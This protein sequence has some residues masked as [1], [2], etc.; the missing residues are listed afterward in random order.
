MFLALLMVFG[1]FPATVFTALAAGVPDSLVTSLAQLYDG[2]E[3]RAREELEALYDAGL[4]DSDGNMVPLDIREDGKSVNLEDIA[5][6]IA[7]GE[8]VGELTVNGNAVT[9]EK[10]TQLQQV[11]AMLEVLRLIDKDVEITDEHVANLQSLLEGIADGSIDLSDVIFRGEM[12]MSATR[13]ASLLG[14]T[15]NLP[16]NTGSGTVDATEGKYSQ[17]Y[18]SGSTYEDSHSFTLSDPNNTTW[19]TTNSVTSGAVVTI[20]CDEKA[21]ADSTFTVTATLN[22]AQSVPVSF[23]WAAV[24]DVI[25]LTED[26]ESGA[27]TSGTVTWAAN[28]TQL[29]KTFQVTLGA[30]SGYWVGSQ[31]FVINVGNIN[32]AVFEGG[33]TALS[34]TVP[35]DANDKTN[36]INEY[37]NDTQTYYDFSHNSQVALPDYTYEVYYKKVKLPSSG[38]VVGTAPGGILRRLF[39][40]NPDI[41]LSGVQ[42][43]AKDNKT[44]ANLFA[45]NSQYRFKELTVNGGKWTEAGG[46]LDVVKNGEAYYIAAV[47]GTSVGSVTI[48]TTTIP[49]MNEVESVSVPAG[50]YYSGQVVPVT[51]KLK[52]PAIF[53]G[54]TT[55]TV[56]NVDSPLLNAADTEAKAFTFGYT[57]RDIDTGAINVTEL[58]GTIKNADNLE[59]TFEKDFPTTDFGIDDGVTL[60]SD[61]KSGSLDWDSVTYGVDDADSGDQTVTVVIPFKSG[62][63]KDW[64]TNETVEINPAVSMSPDM[65]TLRREHI[66][67]AHISPR[68]AARHATPFTLSAITPTHWRCASARP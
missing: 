63:A 26:A 54:G 43:N 25:A 10:L 51:V 38:R 42:N 28:D 41:P 44:L 33:K 9:P 34:K 17:P 68:T 66:S 20:S 40:A 56:N 30:K 61:V 13:S 55:L 35:V 14:A 47:K 4:I 8:K 60:S 15:D 31:C 18:I 37:P 50:T 45:G 19:Y 59:M 5:Q 62:A 46:A 6:R 64:V 53:P 32:N 48:T 27:V 21:S 22:K 11:N 58:N 7:D 29:T 23:D 1:M 36:I 24:S 2:D 39:L 57:V 52:D 16:E 49:T 65:R 67:R 3:T 12:Q